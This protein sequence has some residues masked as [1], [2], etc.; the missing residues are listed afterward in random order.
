V[1]PVL[2]ALIPASQVNPRYYITGGT[3]YCLTPPSSLLTSPETTPLEPVVEIG[4]KGNANNEIDNDNIESIGKPWYTNSGNTSK[5]PIFMVFGAI[6]TAVA[7]GL[8]F[9]KK[10]KKTGG[11]KLKRGK[12]SSKT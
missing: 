1:P 11:K 9:L 6:A 7:G 2:Y 5:W 4:E 3:S 10:R 12:S 8:V